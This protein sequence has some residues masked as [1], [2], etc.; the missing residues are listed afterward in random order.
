MLT[1]IDRALRRCAAAL[2]VAAALA[3][4]AQ[5]PRTEPEPAEPDLVDVGYGTQE[6][7]R[8]TA[9]VSSVNAGER[10]VDTWEQLLAGRVPGLEVISGPTGMILR[11][12]G[13]STILADS[14]PLVVVDGTPLSASAILFSAVS[15]KDVQRIEVLKDAGS[16]AIYGSRGANGVILVTTKKR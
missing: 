14:D 11:I 3:A 12:R 6:R 2:T 15:P 1:K 7:S 9:A 13:A 4:C 5:K 10:G 16:T 8:T